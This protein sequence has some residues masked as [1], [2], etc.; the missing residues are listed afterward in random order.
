MSAIIFAIIGIGLVLAFYKPYVY[1]VYFG[2]LGS[3][4]GA[5]GITGFIDSIYPMYSLIMRLILAIAMTVALVRYYS[6]HKRSSISKW[7]SISLLYIV[8]M[9]AMLVLHLGELSIMSFL[10][11][12]LLTICNFGPA[13]LI[14]WMVYAN[15]FNHK[16]LLLVYSVLQCSIAFIIIYGSYFGFPLLNVFNAGLYNEGYFYL[17]DNNSMVALPNNFYLAFVGKNDYFI[18]CGQFHNSNGLG[19]ASGVLIFLSLSNFFED[20]REWL[21]KLFFIVIGLFA[22]LLWC[23]TGTRGPIVGIVVGI[24]TYLI[25]SKK[26]NKGLAIAIGVSIVIALMVILLFASDSSF[27]NYFVGSSTNESFESRRALNDN[28]FAHFTD[29]FLTG[30]GGDM[31]MLFENEIDPH[32]LPMRIFCLYGIIPAIIVTI[33]TIIRPLKSYFHNR[34]ALTLYASGCFWLTLFIGLTNN[35]A[36]NIL[37]WLV[38]GEFIISISSGNTDLNGNKIKIREASA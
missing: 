15:Q 9:I 23:N 17:D 14:I 2:L 19:F 16:R 37:Y 3:D 38:L 4:V 35:F 26:N 34:E 18:R 20:K 25:V 29:F 22:F 7:I 31:T 12:T 11:R 30:C 27:I 28:A 33:L 32:E 24:M 13:A 5:R 8:S 21:S 36:E 10:G 6:Q 1:V